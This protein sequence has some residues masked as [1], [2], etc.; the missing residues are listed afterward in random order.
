M[1]SYIILFTC[2]LLPICQSIKSR[3]KRI[4]Q[5]DGDYIIIVI[6][7]ALCSHNHEMNLNTIVWMELVK[8][9][10][11][12]NQETKNHTDHLSV[13]YYIFDS[14]ND[15][16]M[17][18]NEIVN[19][20]LSDKMFI[21]NRDISCVVTSNHGASCLSVHKH[22]GKIA[23]IISAVSQDLTEHLIPV[24]S[25]TF[26]SFISITTSSIKSSEV[27]DYLYSSTY[28]TVDLVN[29]LVKFLKHFKARGGVKKNFLKLILIYA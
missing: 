26:S 16:Q 11:D 29:A 6:L 17:I 2:I 7:P 21:L 23:G 3:E 12:E 25:F 13:G 18:F 9:L 10:I 20:V 14:H 1:K 5:K 24:V 22:F 15:I 4:L 27:Y 8:Y 19:V 28:S